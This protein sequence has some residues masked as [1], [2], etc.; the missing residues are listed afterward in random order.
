[1]QTF[2]SKIFR[3]SKSD[4]FTAW[5]DAFSDFQQFSKKNKKSS[6]SKIFRFSKSGWSSFT[7]WKQHGLMHFQKI[8]IFKN[9]PA[10]CWKLLFSEN[11]S[12]HAVFTV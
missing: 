4:G 6:P 10:I 9:F 11:A 2:A 1:M 12:I 3:F 8:T 5:I 7:L